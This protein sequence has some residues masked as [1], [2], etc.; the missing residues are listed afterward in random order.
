M[1]DVDTHDIIDLYRP[2][3]DGRVVH[4]NSWEFI[5]HINELYEQGGFRRLW[6]AL[7][8]IMGAGTDSNVQRV[9]L[10]DDGDFY[11]E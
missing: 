4:V 3:K 9:I 7:R 1:T 10:G 6:F 11:N 5:D 8:F 2:P